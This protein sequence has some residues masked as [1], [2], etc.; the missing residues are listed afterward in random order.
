MDFDTGLRI[1]NTVANY[2]T[3]LFI[4]FILRTIRKL[5][6]P[7]QPKIITKKEQVDDRPEGWG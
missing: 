7:E 6:N 2:A 5:R 1:V 4:L 3:A